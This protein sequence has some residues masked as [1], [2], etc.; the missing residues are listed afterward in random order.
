[1]RESCGDNG[2]IGSEDALETCRSLLGLVAGLGRSVFP[3]S[4]EA[5]LDLK[6]VVKAFALVFGCAFA[7]T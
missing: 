2:C 1:M 4:F 7:L 6:V 5:L 3:A